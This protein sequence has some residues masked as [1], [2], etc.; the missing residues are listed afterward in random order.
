MEEDDNITYR[1]GSLNDPT[2]I[3]KSAVDRE[4]AM[5]AAG[6][7]RRDDCLVIEKTQWEDKYGKLRPAWTTIIDAEHQPGEWELGVRRKQA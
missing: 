5:F 7:L 3:G 4:L 6:H 1:V 2:N